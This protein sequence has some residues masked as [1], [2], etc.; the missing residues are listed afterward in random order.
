M[1]I[2]FRRE[3]GGVIRSSLT[4]NLFSK[5]NLYFK[6][7]GHTKMKRNLFVVLLVLSIFVFTSVA[8]AADDFVVANGFSGQDADGYFG[9]Y[10]PAYVLQNG[11][12]VFDSSIDNAWVTLNFK[13]DN[14]AANAYKYAVI[15]L[16]A[17]NP[18][19]AAKVH[20]TLGNVGKSFTDWGITL[21]TTYTTYAIDLAANGLTKWG[22]GAKGV[23]DFALNKADAKNAK[24]YVS[25]IVLTNNPSSITSNTTSAST[26][27]SSSTTSNATTSS[28]PKTG[29]NTTFMLT[30]F[31]LLAFASGV[32]LLL[33]NKKVKTN[34]H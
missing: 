12:L 17:D 29:D 9:P 25:K 18:Q 19:D 16:K 2:Y 13:D 27:N 28:N 23:P 8:M 14:L 4:L 20:M 7:K 3:K 5:L 30:L 15:T 34:L 10:G 6:R 1:L 32:V 26:N 31:S 21:N 11:A 24:I 22:D 33:M